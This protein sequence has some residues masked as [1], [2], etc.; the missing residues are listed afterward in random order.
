[1]RLWRKQ[2]KNP[3]SDFCLRVPIQDGSGVDGLTDTTIW[4]MRS[5]YSTENNCQ[6]S[7]INK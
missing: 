7:G 2:Q 1:M 4:R 5:T 3:A 6:D